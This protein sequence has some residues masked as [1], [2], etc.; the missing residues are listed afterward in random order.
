MAKHMSRAKDHTNKAV[1]FLGERDR[2]MSSASMLSDA[3]IL[4]N[5]SFSSLS[6][7]MESAM[8]SAESRTFSTLLKSGC[9]ICGG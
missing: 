1:D 3:A 6:N 9:W 2:R 5:L 8:L 4:R 7:M